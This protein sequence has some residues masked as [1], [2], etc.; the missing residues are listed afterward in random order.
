VLPTDAKPGKKPSATLTVSSPIAYSG[1]TRDQHYSWPKF[2]KF[3]RLTLRILPQNLITVL[4]LASTAQATVITYVGTRSGLNAL[5]PTDTVA[6]GTLADETG[7]SI[8]SPYVVT[9]NPSSITTTATINT[10]TS[11]FL[12]FVEGSFYNGNFSPNDVL[13]STAFNSSPIVISFSIP[14]Q[15]FGLQIQ[16]NDT[17]PFTASLTAFGAGNVNFGTVTVNG[18]STIGNGDNT[19]PFLGI[20]SNLTDIVAISLAVDGV[21]TDFAINQATL[22]KSL[23]NNTT[24]EP[25]TVALGGIGF[26]ALM[27]LR[28]RK[29][30][31][32]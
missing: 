24:P 29:D 28:L 18:T 32:G 3:R 12:I 13:L 10:G 2:Y 6:W 20:F 16:R 30:D 4:L 23:N 7:S 22:L 25:G 15:G 17:G 26:I 21:N 14:I 5:G 11:N 31:R 27:L 9:S 19:A 1:Q 8:A